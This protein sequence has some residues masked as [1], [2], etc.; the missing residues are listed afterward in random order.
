ME[1]SKAQLLEL[2]RVG[3]WG[4]G[5]NEALFSEVKWQEVLSLAAEQTVLGVI[6]PAIEQLPVGCQPTRKQLL[7]LHQLATLN[8]QQYAHHAEVLGE[9]LDLL[10]RAG[11]ERPVLLK[12]LGVGLNYPDPTLRQCG[13]LDIYVGQRLFDQ[14]SSFLAKELNLS[15]SDMHDSEQHLHFQY[16]DVSIEIH[17]YA[18][19]YKALA[20]GAKEFLAYCTDELEGDNLREEEIAGVKVW[21]PPHTF[22]YIYIFYHTLRH[23]LTSGVGFRQVCDWC[24]H[25][26]AFHS[27][28]NREEISK[29][30][31]KYK[32]T[33]MLGVFQTIAVRGMGV[34][35][36]LIPDYSPC[37]DDVYTI[38]IER[39]WE[40][41]NFGCGNKS[42]RRGDMSFVTR[43][44]TGFILYLREMRFFIMIDAR[45]SVKYYYKFITSAIISSLKQL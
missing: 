16:K 43:K 4:G 27:E 34:A 15:T 19:N 22:N 38:A 45:F 37:S 42:R 8:R 20:F 1:R 18:S 23:F 24:C 29:N 9:V 5:V 13:D 40:R 44:F 28:L 6:I 31:R 21:L 35:P 26:K 10:R 30:I 14:C 41:G 11:A 17:R 32:L 33:K 36:E 2:I 12:G 7:R 39:V 25:I 3:L